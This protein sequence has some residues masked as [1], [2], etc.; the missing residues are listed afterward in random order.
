MRRARVNFDAF[1]FQRRGQVSRLF[2][3]GVHEQ[4]ARLAVAEHQAPGNVVV[5]ERVFEA[6]DPSRKFGHALGDDLLTKAK[7]VFP[8]FDFDLLGNDFVR[9]AIYLNF[10][11]VVVV[12]TAPATLVPVVRVICPDRDESVASSGITR[13]TSRS[14]FD[15]ET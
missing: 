15:Q 8:G 11:C 2:D 10:A 12:G 3:I 1:L 9:A 13:D 14:T 5:Q 4:D 6:G 7:M